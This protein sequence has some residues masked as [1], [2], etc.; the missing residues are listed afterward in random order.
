MITRWEQVEH[1]HLAE[2]PALPISPEAWASPVADMDKAIGR[3]PLLLGESCRIAWASVQSVAVPDGDYAGATY[4]AL[5]IRTASGKWIGFRSIMW[6][7][8]VMYELRSLQS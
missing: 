4:L 5:S 8:R 2:T 1:L 3:L 6:P 7:H